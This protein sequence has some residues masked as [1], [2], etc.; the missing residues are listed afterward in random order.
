MMKICSMITAPPIS[1]GACRPTSVTTGISALRSAWRDDHQVLAQALGPGGADVVLAQ[2][3]EHHGAG[4]P[5]RDG[6][7]RRAEDDAGKHH[8][9]QVGAAGPRRTATYFD[10]RRPTPPD[11][12]EHHH[13]GAEPE[14]G[15]R[16]QQDRERAGNV[17]AGGVLADR[18][19]D[20]DRQRDRSAPT[21]SAIA[22][23][24]KVTGSRA[25]SSS[26]TG[27]L[28]HSDL[29][30]SPCSRM[31]RPSGRIAATS[32]RRGRARRSAARGSACRR[33]TSFWLSIRSMTS[34]GISRTVT[35]TM[36]L[37]KSSV[38]ISASRRRTM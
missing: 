21:I 25:S 13:H 34:P 16:Q 27:V 10:L 4:Q 12:R 6:R 18:R 33:E 28:C 38:G 8:L 24:S 14:A 23:S 1:S 11:R 7:Q 36:M 20:A 5:H 22:P 19:V 37:A 15:H 29:P 3:L 9:L 30:R 32:A 2:H 26:A 35:N 17:V 31:R